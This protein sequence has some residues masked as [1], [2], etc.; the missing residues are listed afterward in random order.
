M[1]LAVAGPDHLYGS[2]H[3]AAG[4]E[5]PPNLGLIESEDAGESWRA[6]SLLG[7]ADFHV[8]RVSNKWIYGFDGVT[9]QLMTSYDRGFSWRRSNVP[10]P[11]VDLAVNPSDP[12]VV[13]ASTQNG[14]FEKKAAGDWK[15]LGGKIGYLA[16]PSDGPL[17]VVE[18]DGK[19]SLSHDRGR[20]WIP[21]SKLAEAPVAT[22][23]FG[24]GLYVAL[25]NG[26]VV[27][28]MN[29]AATWNTRVRP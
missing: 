18:A 26:T 12:R 13:L 17:Y 27:Q 7:R 5:L 28:S 9:G 25:V 8:I 22:N 3:P 19:V 24:K 11:I 20:T 29:R 1:G 21:R 23:S 6:V 10:A 15:R 16:W 14:L 4:A 2:G